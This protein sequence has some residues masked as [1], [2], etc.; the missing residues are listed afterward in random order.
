LTDRIDP[1]VDRVLE[2]PAQY[3]YIAAVNL[4][5]GAPLVL[6][7]LPPE[8]LEKSCSPD[9]LGRIGFLSIDF[10]ASGEP[11][12]RSVFKPERFRAKIAKLADEFVQQHEADWEI[13]A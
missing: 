12:T 4:K 3:R 5:D 10:S 9:G 6:P 7:G 11:A 13:R 8:L 2:I 1:L